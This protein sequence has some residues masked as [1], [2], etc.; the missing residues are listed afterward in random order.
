MQTNPVLAGQCILNREIY[1]IRLMSRSRRRL[2]R[3]AC[4]VEAARSAAVCTGLAHI[5]QR[6]KMA[7]V[8]LSVAERRSRRPLA[9]AQY[10]L[11]T[12]PD[13]MSRPTVTIIGADGAASQNT[14]PL[15]NVFKAPIRADIVQYDLSDTPTSRWKRKN[16][17]NG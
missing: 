6:R 14:H 10:L 12:Q 1:H 15:P 8:E 4:Q 13:K 9:F 3:S 17:N 11:T 2:S 16:S 5:Q 7:N